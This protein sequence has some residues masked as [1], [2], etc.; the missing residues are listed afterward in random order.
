M[1]FVPWYF[2]VIWW[3]SSLSFYLLASCSPLSWTARPLEIGCEGREIRAKN[4]PLFILNPQRPRLHPETG[5]LFSSWMISQET[6]TACSRTFFQVSPLVHPVSLNLLQWAHPKHK[7]RSLL[8]EDLLL[9]LWN[10]PRKTPG[11]ELEAEDRSKVEVSGEDGERWG[12]ERLRCF[13]ES[14]RVRCLFT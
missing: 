9:F 14:A 6:S 1:L 3:S 8:R 5:S 7:L 4:Q 2:S 13:R 12:R 10:H 11:I